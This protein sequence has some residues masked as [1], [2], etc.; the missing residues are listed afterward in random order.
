[1][2]TFLRPRRTSITW[3]PAPPPEA[4]AGGKHA[5]SRRRPF[6]DSATLALP[7]V[8]EPP[9]ARGAG[10]CCSSVVASVQRDTASHHAVTWSSEGH[11]PE[12]GQRLSREEVDLEFSKIL[13]SWT[14]DP[15]QDTFVTRQSNRGQDSAEA[16]SVCRRAN[17]RS[18][19]NAALTSRD[20]YQVLTYAERILEQQESKERAKIPC[21][22]YGLPENGADPWGLPR[23]SFSSNGG[24][25]DASK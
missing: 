15:A 25:K 1:M 4:S 13:N 17:T 9:S 14:S 21:S 16:T 24:G 23:L 18:P 10:L 12:A 11:E 22:I 6:G 19:D 5:P 7:P 2:Q 3:M 20:G 8:K